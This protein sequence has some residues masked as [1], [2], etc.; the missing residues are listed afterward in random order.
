MKTNF[1]VNERHILTITLIAVMCLRSSAQNILGGLPEPF[2]FT[3]LQSRSVTQENPTGG[4]GI[5]GKGRGNGNQRKGAP[6]YRDIEPGETKTLCDIEG[7]GMIRHIWITIDEPEK[8]KPEQLR[9][10]IIRMYWDGSEF[11]SVEAPLSDF[12]GTSHGRISNTM[13]PYITTPDG[14]GYN[15]YFPMPFSKRA[16][17]TLQN[18]SPNLL[19]WIFY[20]V[21]YTLGDKVTDDM[22]RF[23]A[24]F[25]RDTP[26]AGTDYVL[27]DTKGS[28]GIFVGAVVGVIPLGRGWWGEGEMKFY[29]DGDD[30]YPTICGTGTEDYVCSGWG[31]EGQSFYTG[32]NF[33]VGNNP[34]DTAQR[35]M[36]EMISFYR[37]HVLDP[38]YFHS[39]LRVA[40]QQNWS[41]FWK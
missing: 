36:G 33:H 27:L 16:K 8:R 39:G 5:A 28:P 6:A 40:L 15:C 26:K 38:V 31:M 34:G 18:D 17:I 35:E 14:R 32:V 37:Y 20:Q 41:R 9:N 29:L 19:E 7:N 10:Y 11:P 3:D 12:F 23:H 22:G 24:S 4:K 30:K 13:T 25:R 21:D 1:L 2:R